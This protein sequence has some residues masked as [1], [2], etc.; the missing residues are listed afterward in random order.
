MSPEQELLVT[1]NIKLIHGLVNHFTRGK[2]LPEY[3]IEEVMDEAQL[4]LVK[5]AISYDPEK[6]AFSTWAY[7]IMGQEVVKY[8]RSLKLYSRG[9][10]MED[11]SIN[12]PKY[13]KTGSEYR[14]RMISK[15]NKRKRYEAGYRPSSLDPISFR[16]GF[17]ARSGVM[18]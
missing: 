3:A 6:S 12:M 17:L 11:Q 10:S 16:R 5:A 7:K 4:G 13:G 2:G 1:E 14:A 8:L 18:F 15:M 9:K